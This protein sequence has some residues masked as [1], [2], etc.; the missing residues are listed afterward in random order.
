MAN[1][2]NDAVFGGNGSVKWWIECGKLRAGSDKNQKES[3]GK[4][5]QEGISESKTDSDF[6]I[7]VMVPTN[8]ARE[9]AFRAALRAAGNASGPTVTL[10]VPIEDGKEDQIHIRWQS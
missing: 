5:R 9:A 7:V 10:D 6:T 4:H 3:G 2:D 8:P 1:G